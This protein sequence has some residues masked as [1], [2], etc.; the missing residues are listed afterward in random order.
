M[1][2]TCGHQLRGGR[3]HICSCA[4]PSGCLQ[5][6][7]ALVLTVRSA[8]LGTP[9][10]ELSRPAPAG[11]SPHS[12]MPTDVLYLHLSD[13]LQQWYTKSVSRKHECRHLAQRGTGHCRYEQLP[14]TFSQH[15]QKRIPCL[16]SDVHA[17]H[18]AAAGRHWASAPCRPQPAGS[19][20]AC[21]RSGSR[22]A[23]ALHPPRAPPGVEAVHSVMFCGS[24]YCTC[25]NIL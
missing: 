16:D 19:A 6:R 13:T 4:W 14:N 17:G 10:S 12:A 23:P 9:M 21:M 3:P 2:S 11:Q 24:V 7:M 1:S 22:A 8:R 20:T 5:R 15:L 25:R 18:Q